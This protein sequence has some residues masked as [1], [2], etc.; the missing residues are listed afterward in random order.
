MLLRLVGVMNL[1]LILSRP[2]SIQGRESYLYGVLFCFVL[3]SLFLVKTLTLAWV[4][5]FIDRFLSNLV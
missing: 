5:T 2:F 1:T 4:Q 3:F